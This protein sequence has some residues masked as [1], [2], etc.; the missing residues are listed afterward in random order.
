MN[1]MYC[2]LVFL[3][4]VRI[5]QTKNQKNNIKS[6]KKTIIFRN[7]KPIVL[8][9]RKTQQRKH[10]IKCC[11]FRKCLPNK[12]AMKFRT[13][14]T[15]KNA[16]DVAIATSRHEN[17]VTAT[18][19]RAEDEQKSF[20]PT[21]S[22]SYHDFTRT[23]AGFTSDNVPVDNL[24]SS[25]PDVTTKES[26]DQGVVKGFSEFPEIPSIP[27][28]STGTLTAGTS[29]ATAV[30]ILT[31]LSHN[32]TSETSQ[33]D[34]TT[35]T[36]F[37]AG[38][39]RITSTKIT[40]STT[41]TTPAPCQ[42]TCTDFHNFLLNPT[43][44]PSQ[45]DGSLQN[46]PTCNNRQYFVS[47]TAVSRNEAGLRCKA[48]KMTLLTVATLE[49]LDCLSNLK[50]DTFWTSGSNEDK[51]CD[52]EKK[53]A[54]CS[55]GYNVTSSLVSL[56]KFWLP[57]T[58][59]PSSLDRCLAVVTSKKG[60]VHRKCSDPLP[61]ICQFSV[62]CPKMCNKN[63]SLFD[64]AGNII[65]RTSYGLWLNIG[66]YTY[67]LGNKPMPW[68]ASYLQCCTLGM[69]GLNIDSKTEQLALTNY[70][71]SFNISDWKANFNYWTS[72]TWKGA[73]AGQW[74]W[75]E[76]SGPSI[77]A[78]GIVWERG[79]PDNNGGN[80][81]CVHFR[82]VL[83][84]TGTVLTDRNC[85]NKFIFACKTEITTTTPKPCT[86]SCPKETC[87]RNATLFDSDK[88]L[89]NFFS[90]GNWYDGCGR[91]FLIYT[92]NSSQWKTAWNQCCD[93]GL[94]LASMESAGKLSCYSKITSKFAPATYGDFWLSGTD[95]GCDSYFRWCS[96]SQDFVNPE[97]RWKAG[98]PQAG[99]DCVYLEVRNG[100][101]LLVTANC[102]EE[103]NFLCEVRK[104]ATFQKAMQAEC[105]ETWDITADQIDLLLNATAFLAA[106]ISI[107][108]KCFLK[109]IGVENGMFDLGA[110]NSI[111]TL[112]QI[113]FASQEQPEKLEQGFVAYDDCS[114]KTSDDEC[115]TA[116]ETFK[117]GQEKAPAL[118]SKIITNNFGNATLLYPPTPCIP[119]RRTCWLSDSIPCQINQTAIDKLNA[120]SSD[121]FG[122]LTLYENRLYYV[123]YYIASGTDPVAAFKHCCELGMK[124]FEPETATD[125]ATASTLLSGKGYAAIVG[126]TEFVNQTHEVWC[127]SRKVLPDAHYAANAIRYP[128]ITSMVVFNTALQ[129]LRMTTYPFGNGSIIDEYL[130]LNYTAMNVINNFICVKKP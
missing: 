97:L 1:L 70:S 14:P 23:S 85:S 44:K 118:V 19:S 47:N 45:A 20:V 120:T 107:N 81:S 126:E 119:I 86:A 3:V 5:A 114:G 99:L 16:S 117:C 127:R 26:T 9:L 84:A 130:K 30:A 116:Y 6:V 54:W 39:T 51:N 82:F 29:G 83:N 34:T 31:S 74:S 125:L 58:A 12:N 42:L 93:I 108:L 101:V 87:V 61:F 37:L 56:D 2:S 24:Q 27:T 73:P 65:N 69:E 67:L 104:K 53:Y 35:T 115:V 98:H 89:K 77:F 55:T 78:P 50:A 33:Q 109:C 106:T 49:E 38:T 102:N 94:T 105:A 21:F 112:R 22:D 110:L 28:P 90:Y 32:Q 113:E 66:K 121:S 88:I 64:S 4:L 72:G 103:K 59:A 60:M 10:I 48:M 8:H 13:S 79:Q 25:T 122:T 46:V 41:T 68:L 92:A 123:G 129:Q 91:N 11:G 63:D 57:T 96:R 75:C 80:E 100:S 71:L 18:G 40:T 128:C 36:Q 76:P 43:E 7:N 17:A 111:A 62:D 15:I 124:F 52:S 95:L